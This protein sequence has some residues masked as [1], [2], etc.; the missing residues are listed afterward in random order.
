MRWKH[1]HNNKIGEKAQPWLTLTAFDLISILL[2]SPP[3]AALVSLPSFRSSQTYYT[4]PRLPGLW[5]SL[6]KSKRLQFHFPILILIQWR[7]TARWSIP[8]C[9]FSLFIQPALTRSSSFHLPSI[10]LSFHPPSLTLNLAFLPA[11]VSS[12]F[13]WTSSHLTNPPTNNPCRL[14][15]S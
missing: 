12:L 6:L 5:R 11:L 13:Y 14:Q 10:C 9:S 3:L 15:F 1:K 2:R 7:L 8:F 4:S